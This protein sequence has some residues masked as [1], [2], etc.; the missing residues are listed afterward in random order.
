MRPRPAFRATLAALGLLVAACAT[1]PP[2]PD[3]TYRCELFCGDE[4]HAEAGDCPDCGIPLRTVASIEAKLELG[5]TA[6]ILLFPGVQVIDFSGPHEVLGAAGFRVVTV[7][8]EPGVLRTD[9]GLALLP[10]FDFESCP[11]IDVLVL[12]GGKVYPN[13]RIAAWIRERAP[14]AEHVLSVCN[15]LAWLDA[16]GLTDAETEVTTTATSLARLTAD[17]RGRY[18]TDRRVVGEG[19]VITSGGYTSG[20][21]G[22]L[23]VVARYRGAGTATLLGYKLEHEWKP[24]T[25]LFTEKGSFYE[26]LWPLVRSLGRS[27][28]E[29]GG[30]TLA[31]ARCERDWAE[32]VWTTE[33]VGLAEAIAAGVEGVDGW[34]AMGGSDRAWTFAGTSWTLTVEDRH[35]GAH[36]RCERV[37]SGL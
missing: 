12:P 11:R 5:R 35:G 27:V 8:E 13:E 32:A 22:A 25:S 9:E 36:L 30:A 21:D 15:G 3:G 28:E 14:E 4:L 18:R 20:I 6:G 7:A 17:G 23:E 34:D 29:L 37:A 19:A 2:A 26:A 31:E 33:H 1:S 16:A 10:D 24:D